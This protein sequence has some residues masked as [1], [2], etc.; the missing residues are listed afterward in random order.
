MKV[1]LLPFIFS[2]LM[3]KIITFDSYA[4][5]KIIRGF[6]KRYQPTA[7]LDLGCGSGSLAP[8]FKKSSYLGFD[9]DKN[10]I[11][12]AKGRHPK[13]KFTALDSTKFN[14]NQKFDMILIVGVL[15]HLN[16][17][18]T[19]KTLLLMKKHLKKGGHIL[20]IEAILPIFKINLIGAYL[21]SIDKGHFI[22][23]ATE[24]E[25]LI[26]GHF[27]IISCDSRLGGLI[28]YAVIVAN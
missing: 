1:N 26:A 22:R 24:Y 28:D 12:Y 13:Y 9:I 7:I 27:S 25:K 14:L 15:H 23:T 11:E 21:R 5:K 17:L 3:I 16:N 18:D 8:L 19:N 6:L 2:D 20:I 10:L 4:V